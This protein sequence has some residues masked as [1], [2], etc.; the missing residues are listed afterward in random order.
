MKDPYKVKEVLAGNIHYLT[1]QEQALFTFIDKVNHHHR[2]ITEHDLVPLHAAGWSDEAIY[3]AIT[4]C[5]MF[6]FYNRWCDASGVHPLSPDG[7]AASGHRL[8]TD[9]YLSALP[10]GV[11]K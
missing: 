8:A 4:V 11:N 10:G 6:N 5:S 1:A 7:Y 3:T 2:Q 9:G